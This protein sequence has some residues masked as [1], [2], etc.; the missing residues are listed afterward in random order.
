M[1]F[2]M[3]GFVVANSAFAYDVEKVRTKGCQV[4]APYH[5]AVSA[6][7]WKTCADAAE[8]I[9]YTLRY[10]YGIGE[11]PEEDGCN[12]ENVKVQFSIYTHNAVSLSRNS[13]GEMTAQL[14]CRP[15]G[16]P[17]VLHFITYDDEA[18]KV[19]DLGGGSL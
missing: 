5:R 15:E 8:K 13:H 9:A 16:N 11:R 2:W 18:G 19:V 17:A 14:V 6:Q 7:D 10:N 1:K 3:L 12:L 4:I